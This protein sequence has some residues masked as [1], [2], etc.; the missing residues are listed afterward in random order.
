MRTVVA[1]S[2]GVGSTARTLAIL[3]DHPEVE[4]TLCLV[5]MGQTSAAAQRAAMAELARRHPE[6][7]THVIVVDLGFNPTTVTPEG[8]VL[9]FAGVLPFLFS[10]VA[11]YARHIGADLVA[12]GYD[13]WDESRQQ[14]YDVLA[15]GWLS[16]ATVPIDHLAPR[17]LTVAGTLEQL[18][19]TWDDVSFTVSCSGDPSDPLNPAK[20]P[21]GVCAKCKE[22][23]AFS[24]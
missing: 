24:V 8:S 15:H 4:L 16:A 12:S 10:L 5:D 3:R 6:L 23:S 2:G 18:G 22:R 1:Y 11:A 20:V 9:Q 14:A 13:R 17:P 19:I 21:C 7:A